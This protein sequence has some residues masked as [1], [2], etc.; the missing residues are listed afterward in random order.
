[1]SRESKLHE[2][3]SKAKRIKVLLKNYDGRFKSY[4]EMS[5]FQEPVM[6]LMRNTRKTEFYDNATTGYFEFIHTD[7]RT[8]RIKLSPEFL[9]TFDYGKKTFKG[10]ICHEDY[11]TPLPEKPLVTAE[12]FQW[13]ID[14][15]QQDLTNYKA[16]ELTARGD[17][18]WK[19][20]LGVG[21]VILAFALAKMLVPNLFGGGGEKA[22]VDIVQNATQAVATNVSKFP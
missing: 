3:Q 12:Q 22:V 11:P 18:W 4:Q 7:G 16:K 10:Y 17:M 13:A 5:N 6:F 14:K 20:L 8:R 19:I 21:A 2:Y 1:M 9:Q 15:T